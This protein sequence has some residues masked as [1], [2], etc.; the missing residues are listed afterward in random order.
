MEW[1]WEG[2]DLQ[3]TVNS[4][5]I[6]TDAHAVND[7]AWQAKGGVHQLGV[8]YGPYTPL[9]QAKQSY[10][11]IF[12]LKTPLPDNTIDAQHHAQRWSP[13]IL[14]RLDVTDNEGRTILGL[15]DIRYGDF[16]R[17]G[18][19]PIAVDFYSFAE[20]QG[21]EFRVT[22]LGQQVLALDRVQVWQMDASSTTTADIG[23]QRSV[24]LYVGKRHG[25]RH[26]LVTTFDDAGNISVPFSRTI[27]IVD[28]VLPQIGEVNS[29]GGLP[30]GAAGQVMIQV[31]DPFSGIDSQ[32]SQLVIRGESSVITQTATSSAANPWVEQALT[33]AIPDLESGVYEMQV[34]VADQ[35]GN[36]AT[37]DAQKLFVGD[38]LPSRMFVPYLP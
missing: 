12:W 9:L 7:R 28:R 34:F 20:P 5:E 21:L 30:S 1:V 2:E 26:L 32:A 23:D 14:A 33:F 13:E 25:K 29:P 6:I 38:A 19:T 37:R 8:W 24:D 36:V 35:A 4:G 31:H 16:K 15:R 18:Y 27:T 3:H 17:D 10:R 11:A 22:W